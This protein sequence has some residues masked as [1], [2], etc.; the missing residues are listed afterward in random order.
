MKDIMKAFHNVNTIEK[1]A[2]SLL[3]ILPWSKK[4]Y[5]LIRFIRV[6]GGTY[7]RYI[8]RYSDLRIY[9]CVWTCQHWNSLEIKFVGYIALEITG[10]IISTLITISSSVFVMSMQQHKGSTDF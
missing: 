9:F 10:V 6:W 8:L 2:L 1:K 7:S 5:S 4:Q 3:H